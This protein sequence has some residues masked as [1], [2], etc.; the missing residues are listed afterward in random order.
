[1]K[2]MEKAGKIIAWIW[3]VSLLI[4]VLSLITLFICLSIDKCTLLNDKK[5]DTIEELHE[6][7]KWACYT[8][9]DL[10]YYPNRIVFTHDIKNYVFV[11]CTEAYKGDEFDT[12]LTSYVVKIVD[13]QYVLEVPY[14]GVASVPRADLPLH[15]NYTHRDYYDSYMQYVTENEALCFAFAYKGL[16]ESNDIYFDGYKMQEIKCTNP[17]T[18][19]EFLLCYST[20]P[21]TYTALEAIC[22]PEENRHTLEAR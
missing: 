20:S 6:D 17:F 10:T 4:L 5:Y 14:F 13:E 11:F 1:M 2:L 19:E 18:N 21:K 7:Y 9:P 15:D 16:G 8:D 12:H 22:I 3:L